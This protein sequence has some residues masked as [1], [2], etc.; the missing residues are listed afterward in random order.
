MNGT[1][2]AQFFTRLMKD[3][4]VQEEWVLYVRG[5]RPGTSQQIVTPSGAKK[6]SV[7]RDSTVAGNISLNLGFGPSSMLIQN[8]SL[9]TLSKLFLF[10][11]RF[12]PIKLLEHSR[13]HGPLTPSTFL[14]TILLNKVAIACL[15]PLTSLCKFLQVQIAVQGSLP[16]DGTR[17]EEFHLMPISDPIQS[18]EGSASRI[19]KS[20]PL[21]EDHAAAASPEPPTVVRSASSNAR[22]MQALAQVQA[23]PPSG[24]LPQPGVSIGTFLLEEAIGAGG[25]GA[26]FR[27]HDAQLERHVALKL[28]PLD[29]TADP[30]VVQRFY[31]EGRSAA[32]LD[33]ENIAR[34]YSIGQDGP[35]HYIAFEYIEGVTVRRRVDEDGP[36]PVNGAVDITLQIAQALVHAAARGVVHRDIKPSNIILTP[37]GRAKLVDMGLARRFE[38]DADHGLTQSGMTLG[39]FDYISPEQARD[40]R[41]VDVRSDLYSLGCTLF[42]MLTGRPPFPGGTVL[43]KLLQHQE[44]PPPEIR[45]LNPDVPPELAR[46]ITKLMAKNRDRRYQSPEQLVRDLLTIAGRLGLAVTPAEQHAWMAAT[47]RVTW[48]RHLVWFFPAL[49]FLVVVAGLVWWGREQNSP[50][51]A[52]PGIGPIRARGAKAASRTRQL[53]WSPER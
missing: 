3:R 53:C 22:R 16:G 48:E 21:S 13:P 8:P 7:Q 24:V 28:L 9:H 39:T 36:L 33:H 5:I 19:A 27:A 18:S 34:V 47:H 40:P 44:E 6:A 50:L 10:G 31:Q 42:Q 17:F 46:I 49:A 1:S 37:Q 25:M 4:I 43:Q 38:R 35:N 23:A 41:D 52:E 32:R 15:S 20:E 11:C 12:V 14:P 30:E 2:N 45:A 51:P 26:V 29:Q